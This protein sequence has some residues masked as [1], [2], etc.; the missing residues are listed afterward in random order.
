MPLP[1]I[2]TA[3]LLTQT[4][5]GPANGSPPS[6]QTAPAQ[7]PSFQTPMNVAEPVRIA[8]TPKLDGV[9]DN[10]EWDPLVSGPGLKGYFQWE[11]GKLHFAGTVPSGNDL[12]I[13][14][15]FGSN[16]WLVGAD[17]IEIRVSNASGAA[18][19]IARQMD[20][21]Q[22]NGP[23]WVGLT[24]VTMASSCAA[25]SDG[26]NTTY[27]F[28][29]DDA[30]LGLCPTLPN[31][32]LSLRLDSIASTTPPIDPFL[33]RV[34]TPVQLTYIRT[35]ALPNDLK[36]G[37]ENAGVF[38]PPGEGTR[39]RFTFRGSDKMNLKRLALRGEGYARDM[40]EMA[41]PFPPFDD[42]GR[43]FVD[44]NNAIPRE[45]SLG[46]RVV[47][48][49]LVG[50]DGLTGYIEA[51]YRVAPVAD[52]AFVRTTVRSK[53]QAQ[54]ARVAYYVK[55]NSG[56]K[57][58]GCSVSVS[59]PSTVTLLHGE[60]QK[61][62]LDLPRGNLRFAFEILVPAGTRGVIPIGFKLMIGDKETDSTGYV[63]IQ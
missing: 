14:L 35:A 41:V 23:R 37:V 15:D 31:T 52:L 60:P 22:V 8:L 4:A 11:P 49:S 20:G 54:T 27:E 24:G 28:T 1:L 56:K 5:T 57:I 46:F 61:F 51:S 36:V 10:E 44:Y 25:Q 21:T 33:P 26:I 32:H 16:G 13:S 58:P 59:V 62:D 42:K 47:R 45:A 7:G 63:N 6:T 30:G 2:F 29:L 48:G 53:P 50:G 12:L 17:N 9:I 34:M 43:A 19:F 3:L 39:L 38:V 40:S 18:A 55:S